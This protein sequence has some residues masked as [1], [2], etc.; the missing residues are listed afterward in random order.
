MATKKRHTSSVFRFRVNDLV[1][2]PTIND[3]REYGHLKVI[4]RLSKV[5]LMDKQVTIIKLID[6]NWVLTNQYQAD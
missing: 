4:R 6:G 3:H 5:Y 2:L 1:F